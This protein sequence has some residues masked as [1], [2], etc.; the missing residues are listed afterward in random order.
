MKKL[1]YKIVGVSI[2][3]LL[4]PFLI[5]LLFSN[6]SR[7]Y[8][9]A[10]MDFNIYYEKDGRRENLDFNQYLIGV[11]A[12]N[13]P[14]AYHI[15]ALKAQAVLSR[16]YALYNISLLL[17][18]RP[19]QK[20]FSTSELGLSYINPD[21]MLG[22]WGSD[23]YATQF[24][25]LENC[26]HGT[27]GQVLTYEDELILP[28]FFGTGTGFT[29]NAKEAWG[30]DIPYL[31]SVPSKQDVTSINY[32]RITEYDVNILLGILKQIYP[33]L[34]IND[35]TFFQ[36]ISITKRDSI[37]YVTEISLNNLL[38]S[39]EEFANVLGLNS[40]HFYIEDYEGKA[41]IICTGVGHGVGLS[42]YG[43]NAMAE[44]G[45]SYEDILTHYYTGVK[46]I[47]L[48]K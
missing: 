11:V 13:M 32:L 16:T 42:Q 34:E 36:D 9:L 5:T 38:V 44:E 25:K 37:G 1:I 19:N 29:R 24:T 12:A 46:L 47:N 2:L 22:Y 31:I 15:E 27:N 45:Y 23:N 43:C 17:E 7:D 39:G 21:D 3:V 33:S 26:V 10:D 6:K 35:N 8:S 40:N 28:V 48:D 41:R 4:L 18:E 14:A 20:D 30:V